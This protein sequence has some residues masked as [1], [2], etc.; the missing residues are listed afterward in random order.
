VKH[1]AERIEKIKQATMQGNL[2]HE[3]RDGHL[4]DD[5]IFGRRKEGRQNTNQGTAKE[6]GVYRK[7][8]GSWEEG[9]RNFSTNKI[10]SNFQYC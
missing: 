10:I 5:N 4:T 1:S 8:V 6:E 9:E 2:F 3:T 7:D